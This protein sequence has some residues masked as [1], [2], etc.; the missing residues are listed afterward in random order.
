MNQMANESVSALPTLARRSSFILNWAIAVQPG[1]PAPLSP[2]PSPTYE[3]RRPSL[4]RSA[5]RRRPSLVRSTRACSNPS[6][7]P[8]T[9]KEFNVDLTS[10]GYTSVFVHLPYTPTTPSPFLRQVNANASTNVPV[11]PVPQTPPPAATETKV[12]KRFRSLANL[13][14]RRARAKSNAA[15]NPPPSPSNTMPSKTKTSSSKPKKTAAPPLPPSLASELLL[16]QFTGGGSLE[17]HAKRV[18][19]QQ[20]RAAAPTGSAAASKKKKVR[21]EE[22]AVGAVYRDENG[23]M[24]WDE[25]EAMEYKALIPEQPGSPQSHRWVKFDGNKAPRQEAPPRRGSL[26]SMFTSNSSA[27]SPTS[28]RS[29]SDAG[30]SNVV[31]PANVDAYGGVAMHLLHSTPT[32]SAH[33]M[34]AHQNKRTRR[35]P[36]PLQLHSAD[37]VPQAPVNV[38]EDSFAPAVAS[39]NNRRRPSAGVVVPMGSA[40]PVCP[41]FGDRYVQ[42]GFTGKENGH[43]IPEPMMAVPTIK[44]KSSRTGFRGRA[45]ALFG[46]H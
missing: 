23:N 16:M 40:P 24:W 8:K 10:Y 13:K 30:F 41:S 27:A 32:A 2:R 17:T 33:D 37:A 11:P 25:A 12:I 22:L 42:P 19:E 38:F 5:S 18:M 29:F 28:P 44:K 7:S 36:A 31:V 46:G 9:P 35:R 45:R 43:R 39:P 14:P 26:A 20:A 34:A 3:S 4:S 21:P 1:S 15:S 6:T